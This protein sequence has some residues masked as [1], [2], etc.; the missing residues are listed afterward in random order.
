MPLK[1]TKP[2]T[3]TGKSSKKLD[4]KLQQTNTLKNTFKKDSKSG[5]K[6]QL[7]CYFC[8]LKSAYGIRN[9]DKQK[10]Q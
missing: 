3:K 5:C 9:P 8:T 10:D 1:P 2:I 6:T 4:Y 7:A